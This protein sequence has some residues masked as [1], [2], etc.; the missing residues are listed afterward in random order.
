MFLKPDYD[1]Y[2]VG[3]DI[4]GAYTLFRLFGQVYLFDGKYIYNALVEEVT[5]IFISKNIIASTIGLRYI[6]SA[7]TTIYF[8]SGFDNSIYTFTGGRSLEKF[9]RFNAMPVINSG[10]YSVVDNTVLL[11][12]DTSFIW[13]RDSIISESPKSI[14]QTDLI[15]YNTTDGIIIG[16]NVSN[17]QYTYEAKLTST[18]VP[19][20]LQ[21]AYFGFNTNK[22]SILSKWCITIY[23]PN[24]NAMTVKGTCYTIDEDVSREQQVTWAINPIDYN[25]GGYVRVRL[26]PQFQKTLGISLKVECTDKILIVAIYPEFAEGESAVTTQARSR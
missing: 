1:G 20:V 23:N 16:N 8:Y 17:W 4:P 13:V 12:T 6:A 21:T 19:L 11:D 22:K 15:Y 7:P 25:D 2:S 14:D 24:K 26:Q 9:K 18:V 5:G 10:I 3:N